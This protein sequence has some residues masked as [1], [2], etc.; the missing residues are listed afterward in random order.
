MFLRP[1]L[2]PEVINSR[3]D[4]VS[5]FVR[6]DNHPV[7]RKLSKSLSKIKNMRNVMTMLHKGVDGGSGRF[8]RFKSGVWSSLLEFCYHTIDI[9]E[10]LREVLGVED[11]PVCARAAQVLDRFHLQRIGRMVH[12]VVDLEASTE[13]HRTVVKHGVNENL[14]TI[15]NAYDCIDDLLSQTALEIARTMPAEI[16]CSLN[17]IFFPQLGFHITVPFN[18]ATGQAIWDGGDQAWERMFT[19][20]NQVYFKDAKMH[21]LDQTLGDLWASICDI[22]IEIAHDLAQRVLVDERLLIAASDLCGELDS[23]LALVHGGVEYKLTRPRIVEENILKIKS[24]RHILQE[25]TVPSYVPNDAYLVGGSGS[26][27]SNRT[28][29]PSTEEQSQGASMLMLT[30]PNYSGKSVY[31]K[32]V[33]LIVYMAQVGS[34][35][36]ADAATV[37]ITNKILTRITTRETVS[38]NQSAFMI[39]LQQIGIALNSCTRKSLVIIDEFG[40]GTDTCDGAGLAAGTFLH[41]LNLGDECPKVLAATHFHEIFDFGLF[42][43]NPRIAFAH[44]EVHVDRKCKRQ[45]GDHSS[46]VTYLYQLKEGRSTVS[47]GAQCAAINGIPSQVVARAAELAEHMSKGADLVSICSGLS[48]HEWE[49]LA[50]AEAVSRVFLDMDFG[51]DGKQ[52]D[53]TDMLDRLLNV[54]NSS[55]MSESGEVVNERGSAMT[56][57]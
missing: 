50:D 48:A 7:A 32:Q 53:V 4:F 47:Y 9:V 8:S 14:D 31:Q 41:L 39:D 15:K 52:E 5:V 26:G 45:A 13:Q 23:L 44:M 28:G 21:E 22:E 12:D 55:Y 17:V 56:E 11:L 6:P 54:A 40:K 1:S 34:F 29:G 25:M 57:R 19:T 27:V 49:D 16:D 37:G 20:R 51:S 24:G 42:E 30:G 33:A 38:K 18:E 46:E 3:L 2:D 36:P 35:V 10:G 43:D